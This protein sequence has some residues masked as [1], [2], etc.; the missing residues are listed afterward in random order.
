MSRTSCYAVLTLGLLAS[1]CASPPSG[2]LHATSNPSLYSVH[3]PVVQRTDFV[4]DLAASGGHV[5][6]AEMARLDGWFASIDLG[7]GDRLSLDTRGYDDPAVR[8]AVARVAA[9]YGML[10]GNDAPPITAGEIAPGTVRVVASRATAHVPDCPN[11]GTVDIAPVNNTSP[12][13]G[14]AT[15]SNLAAMVA[16]PNDLVA[17][18]DASVT[19]TGSAATRAIRGYRETAPTGRGGLQQVSTRQGGNQ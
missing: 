13:Y 7:Y 8:Q 19:G 1:A 4:F 18:R 6:D 15:N 5:S 12:N 14:C 17:G 2:Y 11:W 10:V 3:Q 16:D 9:N